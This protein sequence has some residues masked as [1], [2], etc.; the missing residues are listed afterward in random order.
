M[1]RAIVSVLA[2]ITFEIASLGKIQAFTHTEKFTNFSMLSAERSRLSRSRFQFEGSANVD[3][4]ERWSVEGSARVFVDPGVWTANYTDAVTSDERW[5]ASPR[6]LYLE[7]S[8]LPYRMRLG[9]QQVVWGEALHYFSADLLH[10]KDLRDFFLNDLE[11]AR[12]P[13]TGVSISYDD[14]SQNYQFVYFP[15]TEAHRLPRIGSEFYLNRYGVDGLGI[16]NTSEVSRFDFSKPT[17]GLNIGHRFDEFDLHAMVVYAKDFQRYYENRRYKYDRLLTVA[18]TA[19]YTWRD[20]LFRFEEIINFNRTLNVLN[21]PVSISDASVTQFTTLP[22]IELTVTDDVTIAQQIYW[23]QTLNCADGQLLPCRT[24]QHGTTLHWMHLPW[25]L[26]L[27]TSVWVETKDPSAWWSAKLK[28]PFGERMT[29][30]LG[31]EEFFGSG[32]TV[33]SELA[34]HDQITAKFEYIF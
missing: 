5:Q 26:E 19:S 7:F 20:F 31:F 29:A 25:R 12:I 28:R 4:I 15:Y 22:V 6:S 11:W 2:L 14:G 1:N 17:L 9:L 30:T 27:D 16:Q 33:Y 8:A 32:S 21:S 23:M 10:P 18:G 34:S 13:Q 24:L 3:L